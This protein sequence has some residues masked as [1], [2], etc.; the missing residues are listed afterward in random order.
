MNIITL[1]VVI[2]DDTKCRLLNLISNIS[3][4]FYIVEKLVY[5]SNDIFKQLL[6]L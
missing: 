3:Y 6:C 4:Y 5:F 1:V 2:F